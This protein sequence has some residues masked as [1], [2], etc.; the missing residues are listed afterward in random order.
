MLYNKDTKRIKNPTQILNRVDNLREQ[1]F[2]CEVLKNKNK[3][4]NK[5]SRKDKYLMKL[6][7]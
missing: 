7:S 6:F 3:S 4:T 5:A 2:F 1:R